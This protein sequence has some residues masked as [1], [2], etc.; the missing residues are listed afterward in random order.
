MLYPVN[1]CPKPR[2]TRSDSWRT[3][4][5]PA[6]ARYWAFKD[7]VRIRVRLDTKLDGSCI[8][9]HIA[10]PES[11]TEKKKLSLCGKPHRTKPDLSN[12]IKALEDALYEDDSHIA[13]YGRVAKVWA[14]KGA[15]L[16]E[17]DCGC[18]D[19]STVTEKGHEQSN[20][21]K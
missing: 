18:N 4:A 20:E 7:E 2:M 5:R 8:V 14:R 9:F 6:V 1:P 15:I 13:S 10:M 12:L 19:K 3:P 21:S 17:Q 16:I 11:W